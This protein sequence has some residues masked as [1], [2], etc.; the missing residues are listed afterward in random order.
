VIQGTSKSDKGKKR[1]NS[2]WIS[3]Q[4]HLK[5]KIKG[6]RRGDNSSSDSSSENNANNKAASGSQW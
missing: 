3:S 5:I 6:N 4:T 1:E 2:N